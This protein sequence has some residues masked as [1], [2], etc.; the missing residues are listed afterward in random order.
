LYFTGRSSGLEYIFARLLLAGPAAHLAV[1]LYAPVWKKLRKRVRKAGPLPHD[2]DLHRIRIKA[3]NARYA[4]EALVP[5]CGV[6]AAKLA[7][8]LEA[9]Q[10]ALGTQHDAVHA[11]SELRNYGAGS[12]HAFLLGEL[13]AIAY[14]H[15]A[16]RREGWRAIWTGARTQRK[17]FAL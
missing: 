11:C 10:T 12:A 14:A 16:N 1:E 7:A 2:V 3:K 9:L 5:V 17:R 13:T 6:T 15:T 8:C 4:A